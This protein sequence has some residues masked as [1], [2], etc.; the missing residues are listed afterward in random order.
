MGDGSLSVTAIVTSIK[1][2]LESNFRNISVV[3]E[4]SNL[5]KSSGGHWYLTLSDSQ[6]S[7]SSALFKGDAF[8][9]PVMGQLKDGDKIVC[10]GSIGV[11]GKRGTFQLI[12]KQIQLAGKGDLKLEFE[13]LKKKLA[14]EGLFDIEAKQKIPSIPKRVA[15]ITAEGAAALQ[16][17][18][19]IYE[20]RSIQMDVVLLPAV[21]Q[22]DA[23]PASLRNALMA[24]IKYSMDAPKEKKFD[25][26]VM[27][28]GGGSLEDLWAFNDEA[29]AWEIFNCPI[30]V[31]SAVG[32]QVDF[33][34]SDFVADLRC[35]TPSAAAEMLTESQT[36]ILEKLTH[37]KK[38][39]LS[40]MEIELSKRKEI[41]ESLNPNA[42]VDLLWSQFNQFQRRLAALDIRGRLQELTGFHDFMMSLDD[43][44]SRM[45]YAIETK[46][47]E[48][49]SKLESLNQV[50]SALGP[51]NVL[52]RGYTYVQNSKGKLLS[53]LGDYNKLK[54]D[55]EIKITFSDGT[56]KAKVSK[57]EV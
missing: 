42:L 40:A 17:F 3:G 31:I 16:D 34:I 32:H 36:R 47:R 57:E 15:V 22:G 29:L 24:A 2:N 50:M 44:G 38:N 18:L 28:R 13:K 1:Q 4:V 46:I 9:N 20:R 55:S 10:S 37:N 19:N 53:N 7:M 51:Q 41:L 43:M 11:Y 35:E 33:S 25:V 52:E 6:S 23:A 54:E 14:T 56:G 49:Q 12:I 8:R 30:P 48:A 27:T 26:I 45:K 39:L 5:S 21:V